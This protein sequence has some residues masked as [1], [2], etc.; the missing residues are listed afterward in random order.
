MTRKRIV[1]MGLA[2]G[3]GLLCAGLWPTSAADEELD[4]LKVGDAKLVL[5]NTFVRVLEEE[6][7]PGDSQVK[8]KHPHSVIVA[9]SDYQVEGFSFT[10]N[11]PTL[12]RRKKGDVSWS[13]AVVHSVKNTGTTPQHVIR[14]ELKY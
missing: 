3:G 9:L 7:M 10:E 6:S 11:K 4:V 5:E 12:T 2:L 13:E 14:I 8:H 1:T